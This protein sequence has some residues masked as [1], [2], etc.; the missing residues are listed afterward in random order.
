MIDP[1]AEVVT[2]LQPGARFSKLV[3]GASPWRVSRSDA[4]QPLYCVIIEGACHMAIEG[5]EPIELVSV[6][7]RPRDDLLHLGEK[8]LAPGHALLARTFR[9]RKTDLPLHHPGSVP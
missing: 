9:S 7:S 5:H 8:A 6:T 4:G 3:L 2:L 1:L